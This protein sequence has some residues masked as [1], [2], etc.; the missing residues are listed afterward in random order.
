MLTQRVLHLDVHDGKHLVKEYKEYSGIVDLGV[1][2]HLNTLRS[3]M[4]DVYDPRNA[5]VIGRGPFAGGG[6]FGAHRL[7][8]VFRSPRTKGLFVSSIGGAGYNF[9]GT[10]LNALSIE[11]KAENPTIVFVEGKESGN[12]HVSLDV[13]E[14]LDDIYKG[15][16][17]LIGVR[18]LTHY[19]M[20]NYWDFIVE[21][22]ARMILV[23]PAAY[24]S[25]FG[26]IYSPSIDYMAKKIRVEDWGARCGGGSVLA[27]AH[28][29]V[30]IVYGGHNYKN[31]PSVLRRFDTAYGLVSSILGESYFKEVLEST[32]KYNYDIKAR[33]GGTFGQNYLIYKERVPMFNWR[34]LDLED[35]LRKKLYEELMELFYVPFNREIVE[36]YSFVTCGEPCPVKC[37][38]VSKEGQ[39]VD[40]EPFNGSGPMLGVFDFESAKKVVE[41]I[42]SLGYDA[43]EMGNILGWLFECLEKGLLKPEDLGLNDKPDFTPESYSPKNSKKNA[44]IAMR[45]IGE[46]TYGNNKILR[47]IAEK[48]VRAVA[49]ALDEQ[50]S[51]R[52]KDKGLKF[53]DLAVY[54]PTGKEGLVMPNYYFTPGMF[55]PL[56]V[57]GRYWTLYS[58]VFLE[59]EDYAKL[60]LERALYE[61]MLENVAWCRFHRKW[62]EK[63]LGELYR[64]VYGVDIDLMEVSKRIYSKITEYQKRAEALPE[65]WES[66]RVI[67]IMHKMS[68]EYKSS[69]WCEKFKRDPLGAAREWWER[70]RKSLEEN[71]TRCGE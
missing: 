71:L 8:V 30:A 37:K 27:R 61:L 65:F 18:A 60:A 25:G 40:Y 53:E 35:N 19:L 62:V 67:E 11:G 26:A 7:T 32:K 14:S 68:C 56:P 66:M 47:D 46:M 54:I 36:N 20:E 70:F 23:G 48:G 59:P 29:V 3:Y 5:V 50:F 10:G 12:V 49:K 33:S 55:A 15:Y 28:N 57:L 44:E 39:H 2:L 69:E 9:I 34:T 63:A 52:V 38:K 21:N 24:K 64:R 4:Y 13:L 51:N 41:M 42:D 31:T 58:L 17:E 6:L 16:N 1:D 43:I 22:K 45:L